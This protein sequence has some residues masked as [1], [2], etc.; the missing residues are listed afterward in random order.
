[1]PLS[2]LFRFRCRH[3]GG[4]LR[5]IDQLNDG[6]IRGVAL[7]EV[8]LEDPGVTTRALGVPILQ[9]SENL[10]QHDTAANVPPRAPG[11]SAGPG[12]TILVGDWVAPNQ[13][14]PFVHA[15][16]GSPPAGQ[17]P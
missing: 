10:L 5:P 7:P 13:Q 9:L 2:F 17:G 15:S 6:D 8:A 3:V 11:S 14:T 1:M 16:R 12:R 4:L